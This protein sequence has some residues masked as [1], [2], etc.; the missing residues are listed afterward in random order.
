MPDGCWRPPAAPSSPAPPALLCLALAS[1]LCCPP[2]FPLPSP[3]LPPSL[4][5]LLAV[6]FCFHAFA[7]FSFIALPAPAAPQCAADSRCI[8]SPWH[9]TAVR[10]SASPI[11]SLWFTVALLERRRVVAGGCMQLC[12][13]ISHR[14]Q[15][16]AGQQCLD[17]A[18]GA[19]A[20]PRSLLS[21]NPPPG[22]TRVAPCPHRSRS[23]GR[24]ASLP[25]S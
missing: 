10:C 18:A 4:V 24:F 5:H 25:R 13:H 2:C 1:P 23:R 16:P 19:A 17:P 11:P 20:A 15:P 12:C 21:S 22:G 6:C 14:Q 3:A 7:C 9:P 8:P